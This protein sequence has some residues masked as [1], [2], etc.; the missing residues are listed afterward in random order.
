LKA[1][2]SRPERPEPTS[3]ASVTIAVA[4]DSSAPPCFR[5][6]CPAAVSSTPDDS[7][8]TSGVPTIRSSRRI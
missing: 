6:T 4:S 5:I 3:R 2:R 8:V 7:R 1:I